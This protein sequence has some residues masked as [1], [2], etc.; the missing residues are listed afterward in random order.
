MSHHHH[1]NE[2]TEMIDTNNDNSRSIPRRHSH[3]HLHLKP[4]LVFDHIKTKVKR[5]RISSHNIAEVPAFTISRN[6][7]GDIHPKRSNQEQEALGLEKIF[8]D[9]RSHPTITSSQLSEQRSDDSHENHSKSLLESS[10]EKDE[11]PVVCVPEHINEEEET[12]ERIQWRSNSIGSPVDRNTKSK[13]KTK[14]SK[15]PSESE[16]KARR[17]LIRQPV[18]SLSKVHRTMKTTFF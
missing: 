6:F 3:A 13:L 18:Q 4:T 5:K 14:L 8:V 2:Q 7:N 1:H 9:I 16:T 10:S 15:T 12:D 11:N 17:P